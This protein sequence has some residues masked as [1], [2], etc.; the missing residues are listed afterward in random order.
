MSGKPLKSPRFISAVGT[1]KVDDP[2]FTVRS[3]HDSRKKNVVWHESVSGP[4][5]MK[6]NWLNRNGA[7]DWPLRLLKNVLESN[8]SFRRNS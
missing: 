5:S 4:T 7:F 8:L 3:L 1:V 2:G 6:P